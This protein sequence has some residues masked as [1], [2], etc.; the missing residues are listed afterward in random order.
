MT[1]SQMLRGGWA[2]IRNWGCNGFDYVLDHLPALDNVAF[3]RKLHA[4]RE[5]KTAD[6][7][8]RTGGGLSIDARRSLLPTEWHILKPCYLL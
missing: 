6:M 4:R 7:E 5:K 3:Y 2:M 8:P 1:Y